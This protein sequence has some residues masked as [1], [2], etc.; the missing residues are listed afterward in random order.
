MDMLHKKN[1]T[2][3]EI[4]GLTTSGTRSMIWAYE[5]HQRCNTE[6]Y[7][8]GISQTFL[9]YLPALS[10]ADL[11]VLLAIALCV[12]KDG[13][14]WPSDE[15]LAKWTGYSHRHIRRTLDRLC[16]DCKDDK[17]IVRIDGWPPLLRS[18][19]QGKQRSNRYLLLAYPSQ[20][21]MLSFNIKKRKPDVNFINVESPFR[22][23]LQLFQKHP[24]SLATL[25]TICL[26]TLPEDQ[27]GL[28]DNN[29]PR[30]RCTI[31]ISSLARTT[32]YHRSKI[33]EAIQHLLSLTWVDGLPILMRQGEG[34]AIPS[35]VLWPTREEYAAIR[36]IRERPVRYETTPKLGVKMPILKGRQWAKN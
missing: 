31:S 5:R 26:V 6:Y 32:G 10:G 15:Q 22:Q 19:L 35:Y 14:A 8:I 12:G 17:Q 16:G 34:M 24:A 20:R 33:Q 4:V 29:E 1:T 21:Q 25:L 18:G 23:Y 2:D 9:N 30:R 11:A 28:Y 13:Y 36:M 3:T 27:T 7:S